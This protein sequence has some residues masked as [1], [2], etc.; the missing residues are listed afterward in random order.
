MG[1]GVSKHHFATIFDCDSC[2]RRA[3][4][5]SQKGVG[6]LPRPRTTTTPPTHHLKRR[7]EETAPL[8]NGEP[9]TSVTLGGSRSGSTRTHGYTQPLRQMRCGCSPRPNAG[10]SSLAQPGVRIPRQSAQASSSTGRTVPQGEAHASY[11]TA[12]VLA[13]LP[14]VSSRN[15][16]CPQRGTP[17]SAPERIDRVPT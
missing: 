8:G 14:S 1:S 6:R 16:G 4:G 15:V 17:G 5:G 10:V 7:D 13:Q 12:Q 2:D 9:S 11:R 3:L